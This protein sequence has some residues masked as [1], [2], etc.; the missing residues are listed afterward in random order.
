MPKRRMKRH[1]VTQPQ[2]QSYRLIPLTRNQNAIVD[3]ADYEWLSQWNWAAVWFDL[4]HCFAAVRDKHE[5]NG[6]SLS[7]HRA[8]MDCPPDK[9]IDHINHNMLD[10]RRSN[11]REASHQENCCNRRKHRD[12]TSGFKGVY[13]HTSGGKW[14]ASIHLGMFATK[15]EAARAYD[16]AAKIIHGEF[17]HL[18]FPT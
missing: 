12:N 3:A 17:A 10:N 7:M 18:N 13:W 5:N 8:I 14:A 16:E 11:L 15:E 6:R 2:D 4:A 1:A 9:E